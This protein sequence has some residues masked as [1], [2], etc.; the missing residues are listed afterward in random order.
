MTWSVRMGTETSTG[1]MWGPG[2]W[3]PGMSRRAWSREW[4]VCCRSRSIRGCPRWRVDRTSSNLRFA[5]IAKTAV[6]ADVNAL[7]CT[8][9]WLLS[10]TV[11][12]CHLTDRGR[13]LAWILA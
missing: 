1:H 4:S 5:G 9:S 3:V 13:P 6:R 7:G 2:C 12:E 11:L 10:V 8:S